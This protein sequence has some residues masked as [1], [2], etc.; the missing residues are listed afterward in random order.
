MCCVRGERTWGE[1]REEEEKEEKQQLCESD[2]KKSLRVCWI[3]LDFCTIAA[4]MCHLFGIILF[5]KSQ[6]F[7]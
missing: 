5:S 4:N 1:R 7:V 6:A 3:Y 2:V